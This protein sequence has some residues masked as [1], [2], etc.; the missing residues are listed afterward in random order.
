LSEEE[1]AVLRA[2]RLAQDGFLGRACKALGRQTLLDGAREDVRS[3]LRAKFPSLEAFQ[4]SHVLPCVLPFD[5]AVVRKC[6]DRLANGAAPCWS[7]WTKELLNAAIRFDL[8]IADDLGVV[9][10][11]LEMVQLAS[12]LGAVRAG[13]LL[14]VNQAKDDRDVDPRPITI[15]DFFTKLLGT[16]SMGSS[17]IELPPFQRG[18]RHPGGCHQV[19]VEVQQQY[20]H[21]PHLV[22]ATFDVRNA[23]NAIRRAAIER[24]LISAGAAGL[25]L[26]HFFYFM[27]GSPSQVFIRAG[28]KCEAYDSCTGVRQGDMA[29]SLLFAAAFSDALLTAFHAVRPGVYPDGVL[30]AYLDD[31]TVVMSTVELIQ[32]KLALETALMPLGLSLNMRKSRVLVDRCSESECEDLISA[33]FQLDRGCTRV[34]GV[35]VGSVGACTAWA[36]HKVRSYEPFW[37]R[38]RSP[39]L[40]PSV[41]LLLTR[42]C[43]QP[44]FAHIGKALPPQVCSDAAAEFDSQVLSTIAAIVQGDAAESVVRRVLSV[45]SQ[46]IVCSALYAHTVA[47]MAGPCPSLLSFVS[48]ALADADDNAAKTP[49]VGTVVESACGSGAGAVFASP[50][51]DLAPMDFVLGVRVRLGLPVCHHL[52][53]RCS[54][55]F[56]LRDVHAILINSHLLS[57]PHNKGL[58]KSTRHH[59]I[60]RA[61]HNVCHEFHLAA[62]CEPSFLHESLRPD[63]IVSGTTAAI[64]D[65]S[66]VDPLH[67]AAGMALSKRAAEKLSKYAPVEGPRACFYP[68]CLEVF[69]AMHST[70]ESFIR[71]IARDLPFPLRPSFT[72]KL[73]VGVQSAL[74]AGNA[75]VLCAAEARL[76]GR[77]V[78]WL[79]AERMGS[80]EFAF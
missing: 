22:V 51:C 5:G 25:P 8:S 23:F 35:P 77:H 65:V 29:S 74:L 78:S 15:S 36:C 1:R 26:L 44:K 73:V 76:L 33:G 9:L 16:L 4:A 30:W 71:T 57:C 80:G 72:R 39:M 47:S 64:L 19:V 45:P 10:S 58:N 49:F 52:P 67:S 54:C 46:R 41:A 61:I 68:F 37:A 32:F 48:S 60:V 75:Q 11:T 79:D 14:A 62:T 63:L 70:A 40:H 13:K 53:E 50:V 27:Y 2:Q 43:G 24:R 66:V 31:V 59:L 17:L 69:G 21:C 3:V 12:E 28:T 42:I 56:L 18:V 6:L 34:L 7:G 38:L 20:D 55:G